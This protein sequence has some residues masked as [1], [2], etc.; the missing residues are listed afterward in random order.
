MD[1]LPV[2]VVTRSAIP[3]DGGSLCVITLVICSRGRRL[4]VDRLDTKQQ[5]NDLLNDRLQ[6]QSASLLGAEVVWAPGSLACP[7]R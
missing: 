7:S 6:L 3:G 5:I 1:A 2:L 4:G